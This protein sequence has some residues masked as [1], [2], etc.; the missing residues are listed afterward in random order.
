MLGVG[1][2]SA[3][4]LATRFMITLQTTAPPDEVTAMVDRALA[5]DPYF[6]ALRDAQNVTAQVVQSGG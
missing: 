1:S 3:A 6:L 5:A 4:P 2:N